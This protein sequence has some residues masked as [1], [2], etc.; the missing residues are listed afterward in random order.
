METSGSELDNPFPREAVATFSQRQLVTANLTFMRQA[1]EEVTS[2]LEAYSNSKE[3]FGGSVGFR[4][5][6]GSGKTHLL[7]WLSEVVPDI[8][9]ADAT[10]VYAKADSTSFFD[11]YKQFISQITR[12]RITELKEYALQFIATA[13]VSRA[14]ATESIKERLS[15]PQDVD[16]LVAEGNLDLQ[17]LLDRLRKSL[18]GREAPEAIPLVLLSVDGSSLGLKAYRWLNGDSVELG[19]IGVEPN[20]RQIGVEKRESSAS[21]AIAIHA[22][23]AIAALHELAERPF[24]LLIDQLEVLLG[25]D[26]EDMRSFASLLKKLVEQVGYHYALVLIAGNDEAWKLPR[27][28]GPRM[29]TRDPL[30]VGYLSWEETGLLVKAYWPEGPQFNDNAIRTLQKLS[31]GNPREILR[32]AHHAFAR[33]Q[34]RLDK[35]EDTDLIR[36]ADDSGSIADRRRLALMIAD[37]V[38]KEYG[39][40]YP[41]VELGEGVVIERILTVNDRPQCALVTVG[42]TDRL[43]EVDLARRVSAIR[44]NLQKRWPDTALVVVAVG[45]SSQEIRSLLEEASRVLIFDE[46]T[47]ENQLRA[48]ILDFSAARAH[49]VGE[50]TEENQSMVRLLEKIAARL[51]AIEGERTEE[52]TKVQERFAEA[53]RV[54]AEP[55]IQKRQAKTRW[56]L[57]EQLDEL[58]DILVAG[59]LVRERELLRAMLVANEAHLKLSDFDFLGGLYLDLVARVRRNPETPQRRAYNEARVSI[60]S[61]LRSVIRE[62]TLLDKCLERPLQTALI[63]GGIAFVIWVVVRM[64]LVILRYYY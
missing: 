2:Y 51:D 57:L 15:K 63:G 18:E 48:L 40:V 10:V 56:E 23:E 5:G 11:L 4:G 50:T 59:N 54:L 39:D 14:R 43:A 28:V 42:A 35:V 60:V 46:T 1:K 36:S 29:R 19:I 62:K 20:L 13:E 9:S 47:F 24:V 6:H 53:T 55:E 22:L 25:K 32:I 38:L 31:G 37:G 34:G 8:K 64:L 21:D 41:H 26:A 30:P 45:Y 12:P 58:E 33:S 27:D 7:I 44:K 3:R 52:A 61:A 16:V 49:E 17:S